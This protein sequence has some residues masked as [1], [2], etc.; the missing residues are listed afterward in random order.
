MNHPATT[1]IKTNPSF[2]MLLS[3]L[4][5]PFS[6]APDATGRDENGDQE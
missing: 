1:N 6:A 3:S 4:D 5:L 2:M